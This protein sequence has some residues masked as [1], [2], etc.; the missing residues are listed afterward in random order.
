MKNCGLQLINRNPDLMVCYRNLSVEQFAAEKKTLLIL[1]YKP[2]FFMFY[3]H[4]VNHWI[5]GS[6]KK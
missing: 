1:I 4:K 3:H 6:T 5:T 2:S